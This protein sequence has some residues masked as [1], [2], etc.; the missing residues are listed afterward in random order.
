MHYEVFDK[1][2]LNTPSLEALDL[3]EV[4]GATLYQPESPLYTFLLR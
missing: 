4:E 1:S 3:F 2:P